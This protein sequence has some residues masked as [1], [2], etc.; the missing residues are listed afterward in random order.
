M[1]GYSLGIGCLEEKRLHSFCSDSFSLFLGVIPLCCSSP[2]I[3]HQEFWDPH[4]LHSTWEGLLLGQE[5]M[6]A[7][8]RLEAFSENHLSGITG[9]QSLVFLKLFM[10]CRYFGSRQCIVTA[11]STSFCTCCAW[12]F[13]CFFWKRHKTL[14]FYQTWVLLS[15]SEQHSSALWGV[16]LKCFCLFSS[17]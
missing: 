12:G 8:I 3:L 17:P 15:A 1:L 7:G 16:E 11:V 10:T 14:C 5:V 13:S 4:R 6:L 2:Q 9:L